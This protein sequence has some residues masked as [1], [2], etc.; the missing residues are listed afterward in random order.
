MGERSAPMAFCPA[1][2]VGPDRL[3]ELHASDGSSAHFVHDEYLQVA[4]DAGLVGLGLLGLVA[5]SLA[6]AL[7][8]IDPLLSCA[9]AALVCWA[10]G[11]LFDFSCHLRVV[12]LVGGWCAGLATGTE[13]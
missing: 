7:R 6:R 5:L 13:L 3:L 9:V 10:V 2:W 4:A 8:R 1:R 12:G 11:G